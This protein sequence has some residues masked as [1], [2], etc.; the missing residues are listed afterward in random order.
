MQFIIYSVRYFWYIVKKKK[1]KS[2][3]PILPS[4]YV[5]KE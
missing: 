1:E 2:D 4:A 3:I 5:V